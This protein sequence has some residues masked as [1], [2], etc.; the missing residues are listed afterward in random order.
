[1]KDQL[2]FIFPEKELITKITSI[3]EE[4]NNKNF[5]SG[6]LFFCLNIFTD[7]IMISKN[8]TGN[9]ID[10]CERKKTEIR[11]ARPEF[12]LSASVRR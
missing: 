12:N 9:K 11:S 2:P 4:A 3:A 10:I 5:I 7:K 8:I 1:M 6:D